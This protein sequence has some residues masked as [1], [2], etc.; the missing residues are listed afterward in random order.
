MVFAG[1]SNT[2]GFG[3]SVESLP[4]TDRV[5]DPLTLIWNNGTNAFEVMTPAVNTD[6]PGCPGAWGPEVGFAEAFRQTH[7]GEVLYIVK[8]AKGS[9][10]LAANPEGVDWSPR[11]EG[12]LFDLTTARV[13]DARA[14]AGGAGV[15]SVFLFQGEEDAF[16]AAAAQA[17]GANL[18]AWIAAI[19]AEWMGDPEGQVDFGRINDSGPYFE[20]V[21]WAQVMVDQT[22]SH[23]ASFD[24]YDYQMQADDMHYAAQSY[25]RIGENFHSM[26]EGW[27]LA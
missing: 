11:S 9:T 14:S 25:V 23:A 5:T 17:Y 8:S 12:E 13:Q 15:D 6:T 19:R 2:V 4:A 21:R 10:G 20:T 3:M 16:D 7:P 1:Q 22:D 24:T 27:A 26:Y 18:A